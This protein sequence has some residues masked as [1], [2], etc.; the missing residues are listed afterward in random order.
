M[1]NLKKEK[2]L[3]LHQNKNLLEKTLL[4]DRNDKS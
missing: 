1:I 4:R 3:E 2:S